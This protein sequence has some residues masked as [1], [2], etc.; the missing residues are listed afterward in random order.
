MHKKIVIFIVGIVSTAV[1]LLLTW[2]HIFNYSNTLVKIN[3]IFYDANLKLFYDSERSDN[4]ILVDID[5]KSLQRAGHWPWSRD[6]IAKMVEKLQDNG[7]AVIVF[8]VLF[9]ESEPNIAGVLLNH[10]KQDGLVNVQVQKYLHDQLNYFDNDKKFASVVAGGD[11]VLGEFF[12]SGLYSSTGKIGASLAVV[13]PLNLNVLRIDKFIGNTDIL[14]NAANYTGFTTTTPDSDGVIRRSPLI[15]EY[16]GKL[17]PSLALS[18][19]KTYL[20]IND[21]SFDLRVL[22]N[23]Q[24]FLGI[25]LGK[26]IYI[27]TDAS[28]NI[29]VN[30]RGPAFSFPYLSAVDLLN[31]KFTKE[32]VMGKLVMIGSSAVGIG[33]LH[34]T[35]LQSVAYPGTE[36]H[37]N[38]VAS[39]L[40]NKMISS[41]A[42]LVGLERIIIVVIGV[43]MTLLAAYLPALMLILLSLLSIGLIFA[44]NAILL[45][46]WGWVLP[47]PVIPYLQIIILAI[48]N[49]ACGYLFETR[50]R[51]RLHD[52]YGQ[53]VSSVY[54]DKMLES[55]DKHTLEGSTKVMSVLFADVR[56]FTSIAE[57]L[58]AKDV[59][60][61]LNS[62]FTPVTEII[63]EYKGTIDKYVGDLVMAFWNDPIDDP[64]HAKNCVLAAL[65]MQKKV[66]ELASV[67]D[68]Q[69]LHNIGI[70]IGINTGLM[71]VGDMGSKYRKAYTVLGDAVNLASRLEGVNK[72]YGTDIL[73][74]EDTKNSCSNLVFRFVDCIYVKGKKLP[75][76]IYEPL[77]LVSESSEMLQQELDKYHH[78]IAIYNTRA[79]DKAKELFAELSGNYPS[80]ELYKIYLERVNQYQI[81]PPPGDWD[82]GQH[83]TVK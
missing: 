76:N 16:A 56:G 78:A 50:N 20:L 9:P 77:C 58:E 44:C 57:K 41:P 72:L 42:W 14:A 67:F 51:K 66:R 2:Q 18:A 47:Y 25:R 80:V 62:L 4:I 70:R 15:L 26:D 21:I 48:I 17:Y 27:P 54:I 12:S 38:I 1:F 52:V 31:D 46:R 7:A 55:R 6:K 33:D 45:T 19:V 34:S 53:Y 13:P 83:L 11:I 39:I 3:Y 49:S 74:S 37:T 79:W 28:G 43:A 23:K 82:M 65:K 30:Y 29:L 71:H 10:V 69:N 81:N 36:V 73:V 59:K 40:D 64:E 61:F 68:L 60:R 22:D 32:L 63:F 75:T 35:P 24:V 5:D 8:D